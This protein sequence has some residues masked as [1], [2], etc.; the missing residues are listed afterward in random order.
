MATVSHTTEGITVTVESKFDGDL[1][2]STGI[3]YIFSYTITLH[4]TLPFPV[5]LLSRKWNIFDSV[6]EHHTVEGEGVIGQQPV[7]DAGEDFS[8]GSWCPLDS[9][10]GSM[11]GTYLMENTINGNRFEIAIPKFELATNWIKN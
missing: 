7:I 3:K 4:N 1:A 9:E 11:E 2:E 6:G 10:L 5:K 8:Y